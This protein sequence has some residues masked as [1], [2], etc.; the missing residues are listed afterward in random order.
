MAPWRA[1]GATQ[2]GYFMEAFVD[3]LA[4]SLKKD[5]VAVRRELLAHDPR[6]L[7]DI[8]AAAK[9]GDWGKP[10]AARCKSTIACPLVPPN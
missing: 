3:E 10:L 7:K 5:P 2:N 4:R 8:D 6:A 9:A 1:V